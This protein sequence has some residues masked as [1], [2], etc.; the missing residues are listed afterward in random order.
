MFRKT[1][2]HF[3][4]ALA[5]V[6]AGLTLAPGA[7][8]AQ[9]YWSK[10]TLITTNK[11]IEV[12]G[13]VIPAGRYVFEIAGLVSE[14]NVVRISDE[15][16]KVFA[17]VI[18]I[19]AYRREVTDRTLL[20]FYEAVPG[21]PE[22]LRT[23]FYAGDTAGVEFAYPKRRAVE[24]AAQTKENVI[25]VPSAAPTAEPAV[26]ELLKEPIVAIAPGGREVPVQEVR[27]PVARPAPA[28]APRPAAPAAAPAVAA[29]PP[30]PAPALPKTASPLALIGLIGAVSAGA[31]MALRRYTR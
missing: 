29:A 31:A 5:L 21:S 13:K 27:P 20:T 4:L 6:L 1:Y 7:F 30:P 25:S 28:A 12:P 9:D 22:A 2:K 18:G 16:G 14:R 15:N 26:A 11:P 17:T 24:I 8:A 23:W 19:P 10:R 3:F